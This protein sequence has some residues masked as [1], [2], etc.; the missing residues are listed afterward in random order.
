MY[1]NPVDFLIRFNLPLITFLAI[2]GFS[3][4]GATFIS[5]HLERFGVGREPKLL[6][7]VFIAGSVILIILNFLFFFSID[8]NELIAKFQN[9]I[10]PNAIPTYQF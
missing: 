6:L 8:W 7:V 2:V 4:V 5:Y 3:A 10:P 1:P 9:F